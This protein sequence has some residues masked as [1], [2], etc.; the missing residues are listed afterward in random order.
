MEML[1]IVAFR[2]GPTVPTI[3]LPLT[4]TV[5]R[6]L[7]VRTLFGPVL[8]KSVIGAFMAVRVLEA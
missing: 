8:V 1:S 3:R 5:V 6:A 7:P 2:I 4:Q